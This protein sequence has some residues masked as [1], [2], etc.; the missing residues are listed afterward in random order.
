[1]RRSAFLPTLLLVLIFLGA[2]FVLARPFLHQFSDLC[3]F[4]AISAEDVA[5]AILSGV[6][7]ALALRL[8]ADRRRLHQ[9]VWI[10][11][12]T[13]ATLSAVYA[14]AN[15]GVFH[16]IG[17]S[18]NA[19]M[20]SLVGR[21]SDF[22]SSL[23]AHCGL[24]L[25]I[26]MILAALAIPLASLRRWKLR[27]P[28]LFTIIL[29]TA[30][31]L[32]T[33]YGLALRAHA[34]PDAWMR[35]AGKNPHREILGTWIARLVADRRI[36]IAGPFQPSDLDD[37]RPAINWSRPP[38]PQF[39]PPPRN[40][41]VVVLESTAARYLSL[42]G[43]PYDTTPH[44]IDESRHAMVYDRFYA[45]VGF[46]YRSAV[47]LMHSL[48]PGLPWR[49]RSDVGP[50]MPA[51]LA[52]V[53]KDR[54]YRTA[55]L[56]AANPEWEA[57]DWI[58]QTAG[59]AE[60]IGPEQL[61]GPRA[62]SWGVEDRALVDGLLRWIDA[63]GNQPFY[64]L[65]WTDQTHDPYTLTAD[66]PVIQFID[67]SKTPHGDM[68]NRY[69]NAVRQVDA[70]LARLFDG[71]RAR[72][73]ADDTLVVLTGD[74]GEA[75]GDLHDVVS[76]G[77]G[78]FDE[79]VRVPMLLWNPRLFHGEHVPKVGAH[80]DINPT[81]AHLMNID[82]PSTWQ[83]AS[84]FSPDHP[85]R[86][87]MLCD[88]SGY[89]FAVADGQYKYVLHATEGIERLYD[90]AADATEQHDLAPARQDVAARL[91]A[92]VTAFVHAEETFLSPPAAGGATKSRSP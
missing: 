51:G 35:R 91:R 42:Y 48:Y 58:A 18:L 55:F 70:Q 23:V 79:C 31:A 72:N 43:A 81:I 32:W 33:G 5:I 59:F 28:P 64:A 56:A 14:V 89:Q 82:S 83:G 47:P 87:Y 63:R 88:L 9:S 27:M 65:A 44:L 2:K 74:H 26:G 30:A 53:L 86:A 85:G 17:Y 73:L 46:T 57:M 3:K 15:V 60:I 7:A 77:S 84:L 90:F 34:E 38:L 4:I 20:F 62:S 10:T 24:G 41:I 21:F 69:L 45:N 92:R 40:V 78:L 80:V 29:L 39:S 50:E 8:T 36:D 54:G 71:L 67:E 22:R 16:A 49:Y 76:H 52:G 6:T 19:R 37:F 66:T 61:G 13:I 75:F 11:F 25:T 1:M 68:M 12:L